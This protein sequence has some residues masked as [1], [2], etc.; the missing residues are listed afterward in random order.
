[1]IHASGANRDTS[2]RIRFSADL[3]FADRQ[4]DHDSRWNQSVK[5]HTLT[6]FAPNL[7]LT[8]SRGPY[9]VGDGL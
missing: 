4:Q 7:E 8:S 5:T 1:M 9:Y 3:R 6:L 2:G